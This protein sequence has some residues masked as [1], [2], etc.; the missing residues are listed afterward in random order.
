M[1]IQNFLQNLMPWLLSG[2]VKIAVILI[3]AV[4]A[5]RF[6]K[7]LLKRI[8]GKQIKNRVNG[9]KRKRADTLISI[10]SGTS[11]FVIWIIAILMI[12]PEFGINIAPILAGMGLLGLAVGMAA[13]DIISDFISG[14]FIIL[15]GQYHV[16]DEVKISGI[17]GE[18][19]EITLRRTIIKDKTGLIH[20][21]P[22]GQ[23]K[24]V[25]KKQE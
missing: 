16:G 19:K 3:V 10:L 15:E 24:T 25:A 5:D 12:L 8:I 14:F 18:V 4:L 22:N 7:T 6:L 23:I 1:F 17:E 13:R 21:V 9:E 11:S 20:S 2:G